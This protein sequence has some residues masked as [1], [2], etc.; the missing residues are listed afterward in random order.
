M[1]DP[2]TGSSTSNE[3]ARERSVWA[4]ERTLMAWIRTSLSL[5][6]FGFGIE[7]AF[8][9]L[10]SLGRYVDPYHVARVFGGSFIVLGVLALFA[11][12]IQHLRMLADVLDQLLPPVIGQPVVQRI[13]VSADESND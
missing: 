8:H 7:R 10:E 1:S 12:V 2:P 4:V 9:Y 11:A 13:Q 5:I 3:L 6:A